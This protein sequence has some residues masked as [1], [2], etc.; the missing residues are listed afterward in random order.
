M[1]NYLRLLLALLFVFYNVY[2]YASNEPKGNVKKRFA[3]I[4]AGI[5]GTATVC[6]NTMGTVVTFTGSG[7][8]APYTFTYTLN[9]GSNLTV[10][11]TGSNSSVTVDV[12]TT[13]AGSFAYK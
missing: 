13:V 12:I 4:T 6:Q 10:S 5:S 9:N 3:T 7:G 11:T 2:L 1:K 8:T